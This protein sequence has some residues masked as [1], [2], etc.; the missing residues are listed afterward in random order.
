NYLL[1]LENFFLLYHYSFFYFTRCTVKS[2]DLIINHL[3]VAKSL[4]ILFERVPQTK[5][6]FVLKHI[7]S[8]IACK[9]L[10]Y[11]HKVGRSVSMG[12][13]CLLSV[14]QAITVN[15]RDSRCAELKQHTLKYVGPFNILSWVLN[16]LVSMFVPINRTTQSLYNF[17]LLS[18]DV[19]YLGL[20]FWA[21]GFMVFTLYRHKQC[22]QHIHVTK[23]SPRL[24]PESRVTQSI[25]VLVSTF[26]SC[27]F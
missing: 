20:M 7:L 3:A 15:P 1:I 26:S 10:F 5:A 9:L 6:P 25:L 23:L 18:Y 2:T 8:N 4:V 17:L 19:L 13:I 12:S 16:M 27:C 21:S 14:F 11:V 24:S 22:V